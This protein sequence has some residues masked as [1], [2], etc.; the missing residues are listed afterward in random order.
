MAE[1]GTLRNQLLFH[2]R[3]S[4]PRF[5]LYVIGP[6]AL[7]ALGGYTNP[8]P[9]KIMQTILLGVF[10]LFPANYFLYGINDIFDYETDKLNAK[11]SGYE[12]LAAPDRRNAIWLIMILATLPWWPFLRTV[13]E[14]VF[15]AVIGFFVLGGAYSAPPVRA[16]TKPF[17]DAFTNVLY[18]MP[19]VAGFLLWQPEL[20]PWRLLLAG[21][22]WCMA[23]H[24]FSAV[25]DITSDTKSGMRTIATVLG[26]NGT[27]LFCLLA[28]LASAGLVWPEL[29]WIS[30]L[31]ATPYAL[32]M[33][34]AWKESALRGVFRV[35]TQFPVLNALVGMILT[36]ILLIEKIRT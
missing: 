9:E 17:L 36:L 28:Y 25:P 1:T 20:P 33:F 21:G 2:W 18:V 12:E 27:I 4:R 3:I 24:A 13:P 5:W 22:L 14:S 32:Q 15:W 16:K 30:V 31:L 19:A 8:D 23:M 29:G 6:F 11:K 35:Y 26:K 34:R 10:F 7:G